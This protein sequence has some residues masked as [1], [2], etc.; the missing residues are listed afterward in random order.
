[1]VCIGNFRRHECFHSSIYLRGQLR[2]VYVYRLVGAG[3]I[4]ELIYTRRE[5]RKTSIRPHCLRITNW[6]E[7]YKQHQAEI[8]YDAANPTRMFV[9]VQG[10]K[11]QQGELF[12]VVSYTVSRG[13]CSAYQ[14]ARKIYSDSLIP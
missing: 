7:I 2:D 1:M 11:N 10:E 3:S 14:I 6:A 13:E 9:G 5:Y 4:E 12:G 8:A